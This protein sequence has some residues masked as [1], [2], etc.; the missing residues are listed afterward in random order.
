M[1][2][3]VKR[4]WKTNEHGMKFNTLIINNFDDNTVECAREIFNSNNDDEICSPPT[5]SLRFI[6]SREINFSGNWISLDLTLTLVISE[7]SDIYFLG[8][9]TEFEIVVFIV[10]VGCFDMTAQV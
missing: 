6:P 5:N 3:S 9:L 2:K 10:D 7:K 8:W 4:I 1:T